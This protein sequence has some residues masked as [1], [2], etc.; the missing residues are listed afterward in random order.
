LQRELEKQFGTG[1]GSMMFNWL[2]SGGGYNPQVLQMLYQQQK[3]AI[4]Q[5]AQ[6][7][8]E[9]FSATG[10]RFGSPA[11]VGLSN[12][13]SQVQGNLGAESAQLYEQAVQNYM[14]TMMQIA[15]YGYNTS[16]HSPSV[17]DQILGGIGLGGSVS[18]FI[19]GMSNA[20][21]GTQSF[22]GPSYSGPAVPGYG[23]S[24]GS[25]GGGGGDFGGGDFG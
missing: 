25:F 1:I 6:N 17:W 7:I 3:P 20:S 12:Y 13:Y 23:G 22:G 16:E 2:Q 5:G 11:G 4:Q 24:G 10:N 18:Q 15:G 9:Q 14:N 19:Q 8:M 21:G